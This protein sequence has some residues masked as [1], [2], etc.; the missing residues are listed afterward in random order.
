MNV[1][2]Q[3]RGSL[4]VD[5]A[6]NMSS[7]ISG[8]MRIFIDISV[9]IYLNSMRQNTETKLLCNFLCNAHIFVVF[10]RK[11]WS[12]VAYCAW[13]FGMSIDVTLAHPA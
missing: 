10:V 5:V 8:D 13:T 12:C 7:N 4:S 1:H 3:R 6:G 9:D 2:I 11:K